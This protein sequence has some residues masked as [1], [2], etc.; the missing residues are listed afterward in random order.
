MQPDERLTQEIIVMEFRSR[1]QE[2]VRQ[3]REACQVVKT[4]WETL[5]EDCHYQ[6]ETH[7][8]MT[9]ASEWVSVFARAQNG[10]E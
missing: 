9:V 2:A 5:S 7:S 3:R 6:V 8:V 1:T 10:Q 4:V